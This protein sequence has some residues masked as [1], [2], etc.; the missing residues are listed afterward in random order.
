MI[1]LP[2]FCKCTEPS[3]AHDYHIARYEMQRLTEDVFFPEVFKHADRFVFSVD[4]IL[5]RA[6]I[7][8]NKTFEIAKAIVQKNI[9]LGI[10]K[11]DTNVIIETN[12]YGMPIV[13]L[14][15]AQHRLKVEHIQLSTASLISYFT[16]SY[17]FNTMLF[18][19]ESELK[20]FE[21][22]S[23]ITESV[24][25]INSRL[26]MLAN[27]HKEI[28]KLKTSVPKKTN[29]NFR[30]KMISRDVGIIDELAGAHIK[31]KLFPKGLETSIKEI[32]EHYT[33]PGEF[34]D[35]SFEVTEEG[36][37]YGLTERLNNRFI[38]KNEDLAMNRIGRF[39]MR[40][41]SKTAEGTNVEFNGVRV[42]GII[43]EREKK[44]IADIGS[45]EMSLGPIFL[46]NPQN[47]LNIDF[48]LKMSFFLEENISLRIDLDTGFNLLSRKYI[49]KAGF[50]E[51][52]KKFNLTA[53][54]KKFIS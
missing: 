7:H 51:L 25:Y 54:V 13:F 33:I 48:L 30:G 20:D 36:I 8:A 52:S 31:W 41:L 9:E 12:S 45:Q 37:S 40:D 19:L 28:D 11:K 6:Y 5:D 3:P 46:S 32:K 27:I 49:D 23:K 50:D 17:L 24:Y 44:Y 22:S 38:V 43:S 16:E 42:I 34:W 4:D 15:R 2:N 26:L 47:S 18:K 29:V 10:I 53:T 39:E 35:M 14:E 1:H 21:F